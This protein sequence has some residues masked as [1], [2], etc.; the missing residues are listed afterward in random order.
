MY[1]YLP[2]VISIHTSRLQNWHNIVFCTYKSA[3]GISYRINDDAGIY[4][5]NRR[6]KN[7]SLSHSS[8]IEHKLFLCFFFYKYQLQYNIMQYVVARWLC[9]IDRFNANFLLSLLRVTYIR[10]YQLVNRFFI[11]FICYYSC[12]KMLCQ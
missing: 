6:L 10:Y 7:I 8:C 2:L 3:P 5:F 11:L 4:F 9:L 1:S 12:Y